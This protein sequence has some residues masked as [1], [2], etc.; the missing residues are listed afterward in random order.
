MTEQEVKKEIGKWLIENPMNDEEVAPE[1]VL[2]LRL[3]EY[4]SFLELLFVLDPK[5]DFLNKAEPHGHFYNHHCCIL[6]IL[7]QHPK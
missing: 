2:L 6:L 5:H 1:N 7:Y 4:Y 3:Q